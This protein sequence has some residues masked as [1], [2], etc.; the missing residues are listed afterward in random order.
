MS[1]L[2]PDLSPDRMSSGRRG[3]LLGGLA[4]LLAGFATPALIALDG[5]SEGVPAWVGAIA[6]PPFLLVGLLLLALFVVGARWLASRPPAPTPPAEAP[7]P[8]AAPP[9]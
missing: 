2:S 8:A 1:N 7:D 9:R 6:G 5:A 4:A 3:R